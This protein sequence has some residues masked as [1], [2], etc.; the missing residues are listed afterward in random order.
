MIYDGE[1]IC[2]YYDNGK[3]AEIRNGI[4][5][6]EVYKEFEIRSEKEAYEQIVD[7]NFL[8]RVNPGDKIELGDASVEYMLDT[9]GFYQ[10]IY[11]F[12]VMINGEELYIQI[13]AIEK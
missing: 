10:P 12:D 3:I 6:F 4:M 8:G 2:D 13:P 5:Q 7:G 9:K 11:N 1:L